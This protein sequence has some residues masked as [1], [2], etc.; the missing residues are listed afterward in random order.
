MTLVS[1]L[2]GWIYLRV[3]R[4]YYWLQFRA[5]KKAVLAKRLCCSLIDAEIR[6][7]KPNLLQLVE[8]EDLDLLVEFVA[9][10]LTARELLPELGAARDNVVTEQVRQ[11]FRLSAD[12]EVGAVFPRQFIDQ[13]H[14]R[15]HAAAQS[16]IRLR[17][18]LLDDFLETL[19]HFAATDEIIGD[20]VVDK[21]PWHDRKVGCASA[22]SS[23]LNPRSAGRGPKTGG[24]PGAV[25][26]LG[27]KR[28][29]PLIVRRAWSP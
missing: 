22:Q 1:T 18:L 14:Q 27:H 4:L 26:S 24:A 15:T 8:D 9:R 11:V 12:T 20:L 5:A 23:R 2:R 13:K 21:I 7:L 19:L 17:L 16:A 10:Q 25:G 6:F 3:I 28:G 29:R